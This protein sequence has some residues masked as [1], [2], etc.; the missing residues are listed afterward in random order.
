ML[1][2]LTPE[3][4]TTLLE[5]LAILLVLVVVGGFGIMMI[6][7]RLN[8]NDEPEASAGFSLAELREMRD[9]GEITSE[10][11]EITKRRV[12]DKVKSN[13]ASREKKAKGSGGFPAIPPEKEEPS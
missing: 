1:A 10:E 6:R 9:R 2:D 13:L 8:A 11:Y 12:I 3:N 5:A 7:R 4:R